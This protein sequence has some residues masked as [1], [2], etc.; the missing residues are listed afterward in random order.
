MVVVKCD[1]IS[2]AWLYV[3]QKALSCHPDKNKGNEEA[4]EMFKQINYANSVL[5][6]HTKRKI[7]DAY[8]S[9]GLQLASQIGEERFGTYLLLQKPWAKVSS[10]VLHFVLNFNVKIYFEC[11]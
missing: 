1:I 7:Y 8:G 3:L 6:D 5:T 11:P 9:M 10:K 4:T 2:P